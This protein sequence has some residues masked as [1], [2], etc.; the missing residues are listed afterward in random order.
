MNDICFIDSVNLSTIQNDSMLAPNNTS[1]NA[2]FINPSGQ[3]LQSQQEQQQ[4]HYNQEYNQNYT[5]Y[6]HQSSSTGY[7]NQQTSVENATT[8]NDYS[9]QNQMYPVETTQ[10]ESNNNFNV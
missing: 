3:Q 6:S 5:D 4:Q 2:S 1:Y 10:E 8:A 9:S 7:Y